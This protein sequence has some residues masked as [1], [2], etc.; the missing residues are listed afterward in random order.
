MVLFLVDAVMNYEFGI[1][2]MAFLNKI[3]DIPW[4]NIILNS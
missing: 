4:G 1:A 2:L 3:K